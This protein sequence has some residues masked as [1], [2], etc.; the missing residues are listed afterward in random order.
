MPELDGNFRLVTL[1][2]SFSNPGVIPVM[3]KHQNRETFEERCERKHRSGGF[4][5]IEPTEKCDLVKFLKELDEVGYILVDAFYKERIDSKDFCWTRTYHMV[6]FVFARRET[7]SL[8]EEFKKKQCSLLSELRH[9]CESA[10]WRVRAFSN[11]F[12]KNGEEIPEDRVL[13]INLETRV[14][15][16]HPDGQ[17]V[18]VWQK[19][20]RGKRLGDA[21][22][23]LRAEHT[24]SIVDRAV[25][26]VTA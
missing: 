11:P 19:D 23:P 24:L 10:M 4:V 25:Q 1:Q 5:L 7:A 3:V 21:P 16:F 14:P 22:L 12:Y 17:P 2:F 13:S 26:L 15:L 6:R 8:S 9:I 20:D 18:M